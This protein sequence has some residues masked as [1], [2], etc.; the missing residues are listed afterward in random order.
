MSEQKKRINLKPTRQ[1]RKVKR[2]VE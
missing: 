2:N 1:V